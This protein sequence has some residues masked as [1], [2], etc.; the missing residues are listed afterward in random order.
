MEYLY[1]EGFAGG[2]KKHQNM[3]AFSDNTHK[4]PAVIQI[5][6]LSWAL[7]PTGSEANPEVAED[8]LVSSKQLFRF[9]VTNCDGDL[10]LSKW[11]PTF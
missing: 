2:R 8:V 11:G 6:G 4:S 5:S 7:I 9:T 10:I 1:T 3:L